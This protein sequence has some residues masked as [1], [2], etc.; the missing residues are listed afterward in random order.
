MLEECMSE[1]LPQVTMSGVW[2]H[3]LLAP[4]AEINEQML[5]VLR[6]MATDEEAIEGRHAPKLVSSLREQWRHLDLKAQHRL[7]ACPYLLV[8][9][10]FSQAERW[11]RALPGA[12]MDAPVRGGY[13]MSRGGVALIRRMLVLAWHLAR[14][15]R[16]MAAVVLGMSAPSA[17]R[18]ALTRLR[19]LEAV[20]ELAPAWILPRWEQQP[21]VWQQLIAA[22]CSEHPF[23]LHQAQLRGLQLLAREL[24]RP[25]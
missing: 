25:R 1:Y 12:V 10:G 16:L 13:F 6:A 17:E 8:D 18:I 11:D 9:G 22:A 21:V 5:E 20:A 19:D 15:N 14:S 23:S 2:D 24:A 3:A 7:S 4:I